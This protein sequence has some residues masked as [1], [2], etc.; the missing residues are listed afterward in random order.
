MQRVS[1]MNF[2]A[3]TEPFVDY[4]LLQE[5]VLSVLQALPE[6]VQRDFVDD[7]R[8]GTAI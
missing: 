2:A 8:F 5:R 6:E 4:P 1:N 7:P 3:L